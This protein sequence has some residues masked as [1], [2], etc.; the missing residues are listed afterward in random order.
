[1]RAAV[2]SCFK[3]RLAD[4][5]TSALLRSKTESTTRS[6]GGNTARALA[7][8]LVKSSAMYM[9]GWFFTRRKDPARELARRINHEIECDAQ[10]LVTDWCR[11]FHR[12]QPSGGTSSGKAGRGG[13]RQFRYRPPT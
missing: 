5:S 6:V 7:T 3:R 8:S 10:N 2:G 4:R 9:L 11:G 13:P 1:M 12:I